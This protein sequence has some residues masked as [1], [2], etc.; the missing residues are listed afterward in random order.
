MKNL[1]V[2]QHTVP[3]AGAVESVLPS[4]HHGFP[5]ADRWT[6]RGHDRRWCAFISC[7]L[8]R[9]EIVGRETPCWHLIRRDPNPAHSGPAV[10]SL[11]GI[12]S[13]MSGAG[14]IDEVGEV[15]GTG[16]TGEIAGEAGEQVRA[17]GSSGVRDHSRLV[18]T[19]SV[20]DFRDCSQTG[21]VLVPGRQV[22]Q[23][24]NLQSCR[25]AHRILALCSNEISKY[26]ERW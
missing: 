20:V 11:R 21:S 3:Q 2:F 12:A 1:L 4:Q 15:D 14:G 24:R 16:G 5:S 9:I 6:A 17:T 10:E 8:D 13:V 19:S 22:S 18:T 26:I 25:P 23:S 7:L